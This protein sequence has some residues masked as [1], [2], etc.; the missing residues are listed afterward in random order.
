MDNN[1]YKKYIRMNWLVVALAMLLLIVNFVLFHHPKKVKDIQID[2]FTEIMSFINQYYPDTVDD[3]KLF[4]IAMNSMLQTLDPHSVYMNAIEQKAAKEFMDGSFDGIG[5]QFNILSDTVIVVAV[6]T[7]GPSEK[8]GLRAGDKIVMVNGQDFTGKNIDNQKVL[9]TLRGERGSKVKVGIVRD[10]FTQ[11]NEYEI[12]RDAIPTYT[13]DVSYLL[14]KETG[15]IKINQFGSTTAD[16]FAE[17]LKKLQRQGMKKLVLDLRGNPGGY[18]TSAIQVCDELLPKND[19]I[20]Y[21]ET[22]RFKRD[23]IFEATHYGHFENGKLAVLIDDYSASASEIVAGAVQDNDRGII[24]G[25]RS[26]GKGLVQQEFLLK[27]KSSLRLTVSQ[28]HTPSGR[29]IQKDYTKGYTAYSEDLMLRYL[30]GEMDSAMMQV[31]DSTAYYTKTGRVVYGG[32]GIMPDYFVP[33][34]RDSNFLAFNQIANTRFMIE[35]ALEYANQHRENIIKQFQTP[36]NFVQHFQLPENVVQKGIIEPY[37]KSIKNSSFQ[38]SS[39]SLKQLQLWTKALIGRNIF[40]EE[41]FYPVI[42]SQDKTIRKA[43]E[44]LK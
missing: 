11:I 40:Q 12:T 36:Q 20:V 16:E 22:M 31:F 10:G 3:D 7:G 43:V 24:V 25:R 23:K 37:I 9:S 13:V 14:D 32:G 33:L 8:A 21:T 27:D 29:S 18:L 38:V 34:D 35:F 4:E 5:V 39:A 26:F 6:V 30:N 44:E 42:N 15:Y 17:A 19:V 1:P 28:Y 2:K 41:A